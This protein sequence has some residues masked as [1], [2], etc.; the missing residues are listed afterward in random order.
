MIY[1]PWIVQVLLALVFLLAGGIQ[2][3]TPLEVLYTQLPLSLAASSS[4]SLASAK[5][6]APSA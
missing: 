6:S 2:I 4:A 1:V 3:V 5:S